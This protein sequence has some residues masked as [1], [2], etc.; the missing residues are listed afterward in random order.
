MLLTSAANGKAADFQR[1]LA[2]AHR[3][4]LAGFTANPN[5]GVKCHVIT[6]H[7]DLL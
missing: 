6:D 5:A 7:R 3:N 1:R 2:N 4:A